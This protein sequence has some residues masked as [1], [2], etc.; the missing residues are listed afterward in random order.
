MSAKERLTSQKKIILDYLKSTKNHPSADVVYKEV[1][2][3]LP[4][5]S[6]GTVYRILNNLKEKGKVIEIPLKP[7]CRYDGDTSFHAHFFCEDCGEVFDVDK[8]FI[9][10]SQ[11]EKITVGKVKHY[12]ISF[13]GICKNCQ[14]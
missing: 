8:K 7:S 4:R 9:K 14:K 3:K 13:Y 2:K 12:L 10:S 1:K 11:A 5:I 6:K